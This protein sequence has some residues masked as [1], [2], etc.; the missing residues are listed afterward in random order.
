VDGDM[1]QPAL[2]RATDDYALSRL[3]VAA[4]PLF[5]RDAEVARGVALLLI[6]QSQLLQAIDAHLRD[7]GIGRAHYRMLSH[8]A[9][10]PG[11]T[12][13]D[14][15]AITGTSKQALSRVARDLLDRAMIIQTTD[16]LDKRRKLLALG[17]AGVEIESTA[18]AALI[19]AMTDAYGAAGQQAVSGYWQVL[20][21]LIP[22]A[23]RMRMAELERGR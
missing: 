18:T 23:T 17:E 7:A 8:I 19:A 6:G 1:A 21:G 14:L 10:W 3:K 22:V 16:A 12:M 15:V 2:P 20:E 13:G 4:S 5:L 9:R 11:V